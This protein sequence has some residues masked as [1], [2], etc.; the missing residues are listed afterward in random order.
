[1]QVEIQEYAENEQVYKEE[2][3]FLFKQVPPD[4]DFI[5]NYEGDQE[6]D[7][8][9]DPEGDILYETNI[10]V[11]LIE[12]VFNVRQYIKE[13]IINHEKEYLDPPEFIPQKGCVRR[14]RVSK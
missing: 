5:T 9:D 14:H 3:I 2:Q 10:I 7:A 8:I 11:L 4:Q 12:I 1:V 13:K 6:D